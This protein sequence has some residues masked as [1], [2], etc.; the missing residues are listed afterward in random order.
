MGMAKTAL[1]NAR[2]EP[3]LKKEVEGILKKLGLS[4]TEAINIFFH[5]VKMRKDFSSLKNCA[6][7]SSSCSG[8]TALPIVVLARD[9]SVSTGFFPCSSAERDRVSSGRREFWLPER[10]LLFARNG[11]YEAR[12]NS[13]STK[14]G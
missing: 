8:A 9:R 3:D 13:D 7:K 10:A 6:A 11:G 4:T 2:T 12:S 5:Q 14:G 1:I